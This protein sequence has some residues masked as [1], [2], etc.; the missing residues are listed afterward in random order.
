MA[1]PS[2]RSADSGDAWAAYY[3]IAQA[4]ANG[5][6]DPGSDDDPS[7]AEVQTLFVVQAGQSA[8][9]AQARPKGRPKKTLKTGVAI[10]STSKALPQPAADLESATPWFQI[11]CVPQDQ[12]QL[13]AAL[14]HG[15]QGA[16]VALAT[17]GHD[18]TLF[19]PD[20]VAGLCDC[21][22]RGCN[23]PS[24]VDQ[25]TFQL[26]R[27][28]LDS[29]YHLASGVV[30]EKEFSKNRDELKERILRLAS[31]ATILQRH[32]RHHLEDALT[33]LPQKC[34][35]AYYDV[36]CYDETPMNI[37]IRHAN[38]MIGEAEDITA[39]GTASCGPPDPSYQ[40]HNRN[41][42]LTT[43]VKMLQVQSKFGCLVWPLE[44][45]FLL[46]GSAYNPLFGMQRSTAEV[47]FE[48]LKRA[49]GVSSAVNRFQ[50][51][52]RTTCVDRASSNPLAEHAVNACREPSWSE[53]L[54][55][56][57][58]HHIATS[59]RRTFDDLLPTEVS[60]M[61]N[62]AIAVQEGG[63]WAMFRSALSTEIKSREL[64]FVVG[65]LPM[66]AQAFK[67]RI[68]QITLGRRQNDLDKYCMLKNCMT[69]DWRNKTKLEVLVTP[70]AHWPDRETT[71]QNMEVVLLHVL[72]SSAP[73][74]FP[75]SRWTG[76]E[77][78]ISSVLL[79][80]CLHNL[81]EG[82]MAKFFAMLG[83][84][85]HSKLQAEPTV[86]Q[87]ADA[88]GAEAVGD[89]TSM[90]Q[91]VTGNTLDSAAAQDL[92]QTLTFAEL[93]ARVRSVAGQWLSTR[94]LGKL[95]LMKEVIIPL[96]DLLQGQLYHSSLD[97]EQAERAKLA[98]LILSGQAC[99][100][101][102]R[103]YPLQIAAQ[104]IE[105]GKFMEKLKTLVSNKKAWDIFP[106]E[107]FTFEF[108]ALSHRVIA[109]S[110]AAIKTLVRK[111]HGQFPITMFAM[112]HNPDVTPSLLA[113][114]ACVKDAWSQRLQEAFPT[115]TE[116]RFLAM[117]EGHMHMQKTDI[118][119]VETLHASIRRHLLQR[120]LQTHVF[121][122]HS[123][124]AEWVLQHQRRSL[125]RVHSVLPAQVEKVTRV[126][127]HKQTPPIVKVVSAC[128]LK[129]AQS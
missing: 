40:H 11:P 19:K 78:A 114:P 82:T 4:E 3:G 13:S 29:H 108:R 60:G 18:C 23:K 107:C 12:F 20:L 55:H 5:S 33:R 122:L 44:N 77:E 103:S 79:L 9:S 6:A 84:G 10:E 68:L 71:K 89:A 72:T 120:S 94:P 128:F 24:E 62:F 102:D 121:G 28:Y 129:H 67:S 92:H 39:V 43:K 126:T 110:G 91:L 88:G 93:N 101:R 118:S 119:G 46:Y 14:L 21:F 26:A 74:I 85:G 57:D 90:L 70:G 34:L 75:R 86:G 50:F 96:T 98:R 35:L 80:H 97:F 1:S 99:S 63:K 16:A 49:D 83:K 52:C 113:Q 81:I 45:P 37:S 8:T 15:Q 115:W 41:N 22:I 66:A 76:G 73:K 30:L 87:I 111:P 54:L 56:C 64:A 25:V 2:D 95:L 48:C 69:G 112:L 58:T 106:P 31:S 61:I 47:T 65:P 109:R 125:A 127:R 59:F 32:F 7:L 17:Q 124:S 42:L 38:P 53:T 36:S 117:L 27:H 105:E 104:M 51:K 100:A 116:P 123:A